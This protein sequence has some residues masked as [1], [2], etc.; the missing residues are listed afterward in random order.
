L[1]S[2]NI[3]RI[4]PS[5]RGALAGEGGKTRVEKQVSIKKRAGGRRGSSLLLPK[6]ESRR[7]EEIH[8]NLERSLKNSGKKG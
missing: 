1:W 8:D 7:E 4:W 2:E 3:L 6:R 5:A